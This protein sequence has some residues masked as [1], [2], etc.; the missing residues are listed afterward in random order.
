MHRIFIGYDPRQPIAYTVLHHSIV[1]KASAPVTV[2][3][4]NIDTFPEPVRSK[5]KA[6]GG[7]TP[8]TWSRF[9]VPW[10]CEFKGTA[11]FLDADMIV[12]DDPCK[13]FALQNPDFDLMVVKNGLKF[14]WASLMLFNNE[15][16]QALTPDFVAG[17]SGL[18]GIGWTENV[19]E[20]PAEWNHCVGYDEPRRDAKLA[21]YT[22]GIPLWPETHGCEYTDSWEQMARASMSAGSWAAIMGNSVHAAPVK[23]RLNGHA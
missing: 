9:L 5:I 7:L 6:K 15:K 23:Q 17:A 3:P 22:Q 21:H 18:H 19:G 12:L 14:E 10:L 2:A 4:V 1:T 16:C 13:L 11:L 8:F 20:L